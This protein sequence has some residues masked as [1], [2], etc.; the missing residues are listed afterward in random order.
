M[1][2]KINSFSKRSMNIFFSKAAFAPLCSGNVGKN[3]RFYLSSRKC[4]ENA[5]QHVSRLGCHYCL[6]APQYIAV[7]SF[8]AWEKSF[9]IYQNVHRKNIWGS[10]TKVQAHLSRVGQRF[11]W[12]GYLILSHD[13]H[14]K[15]EKKN[16]MRCTDVKGI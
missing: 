10:Q 7:E 1:L 9:K 6:M 8:F 16:V 15:S 11:K 2:K 5:P 13:K 4:V 12:M 3:A 14:E